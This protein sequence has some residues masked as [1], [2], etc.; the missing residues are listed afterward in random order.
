MTANKTPLWIPN[1]EHESLLTSFIRYVAKK[2]DLNFQNYDELHNWSIQPSGDFWN[3]FANY[4]EIEFKKPPNKIVNYASH[5][6]D[7][8]WFTDSELNFA[9]NL[10][11]R[12]DNNPAIIY[13]DERGRRTELT[14]KQL[15]EQVS[16]LSSALI[17]LGVK[18]GDVVAAVMTNCPDTVI[19]ML[20]SSSIGAIW[21]SCS[22]DFGIDSILDR[23]GQVKPKILFAVDGYQYGGKTFETL[24]SIS[25]LGS[26]IKSIEQIV[27]VAN[28]NKKPNIK[29]IP[30]SLMISDLIENEHQLN[31]ESLPFDHPLFIMYSSGTTG[32]P[33]CIIHGAGGTL[34]QHLKEH[35]LHTNLMVNDRIFFYTTCS[36]MMWNWLVTALASKAT[37]ILYEGSPFYP[38][39]NTLW[40]MVDEENINVFGI[41]PRYLSTLMKEKG[42]PIK[43]NRL[44]SLKTILSTGSSLLPS[45]YNYVYESVK[46]DVQLSSISGGTDIIS[47]FALGNANLPVYSGEIQSLGLGMSV[48][49]FDKNGKKSK[50]GEKGELVCT[51]PFPSMPIGFFNDSNKQQYKKSYF[52][53]FE[54]IWTHGDYAELTENNGLIIHGRS[55]ATLNPGGVRIGT[56]EIY[57]QVE[58][59]PEILESVAI[60][61]TGNQDTLITLFVLL[62]E[63]QTLTNELKEKIK[64][65]LKINASPRHVPKKIIAVPDIPR[66]LSGK[67][68]ELSVKAAIEGREIENI[69]ALANPDSLKFFNKEIV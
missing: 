2:Y 29:N 52:E 44:D 30:K 25:V 7:T 62:K 27:I 19:A 40:D 24:P 55:D 49:V 37:I 56:A 12:K 8:E 50:V 58:K 3:A 63:G 28:L 33:K 38:N 11:K 23:I 66:T 22:P 31:F 68:A 46:Q 18:K 32:K 39:Q 64:Q 13:R 57:R 15:F 36:W 65:H 26:K 61:E 14:Y 54:N 9:A 1:Q 45:H 4:S 17:R 16:Q 20:A 42:M 21:T 47:C 53:K 35:Q 67:T 34:I 5:I 10:L 43:S 51:K 60:S 41:S 6:M 48:E 59:I 69:N